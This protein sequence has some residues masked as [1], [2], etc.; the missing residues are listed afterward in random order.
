MNTTEATTVSEY[1]TEFPEP[2][3][4][5]MKLIR[6]LIKKAAPEATEGISYHMPAYKLNRKPLVYFGGFAN[7]I[8]FYATPVTHEHFKDQLS[9]YKIGKGSV[10]FPHSEPLPEQL[11]LAM[12]Q[13]KASELSKSFEL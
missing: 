7:H 10:Q 2:V 8:G 5:K 4:E 6:R 9:G 1:I 3:Q 12:I 13:F 11:I